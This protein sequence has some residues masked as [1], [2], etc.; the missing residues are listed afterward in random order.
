MIELIIITLIWLIF[1]SIEDLKTREVSDWLSYSLIIIAL[2]F[3][4]YETIIK[5]DFSFILGSLF[6]GLIFFLIGNLMYYTRQWGGGDV[7]LLTGLGTLF[8]VYPKELLNYFSPNL[9]FPFLMIILINIIIFG[10]LYSLIY[11]F[12]LA[13]RNKEK[14][15]FKINKLIL[16]IS[17]VIASSSFFINDLMLKLLILFL[18]L[19]ILVYPHLKQFISVV[20][21]NLMIKKIS[22]DKLTEGEWVIEDIY[23]KNKLIYNKNNPGITNQE[24][25]LLK[26]LKIKYVTIKMGMPFIPSFLIAFVISLIFGNLLRI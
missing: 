8:Y 25:T 13:L 7:K 6:G 24:I 17:I 9:E 18:S 1:A 2:F 23:H 4:L 21:N 12:Y 19:I 14:I 16:I 3:N 20:E 15:N 11:I 10:S 26:K 5:K 22:L